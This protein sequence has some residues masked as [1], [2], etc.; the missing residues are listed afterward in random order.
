MDIMPEF[1]G[2]RVLRKDS[3]DARRR[4]VIAR[5]EVQAAIRKV[6]RVEIYPLEAP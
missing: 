2:T 4:A 5:P 6:G 1:P 3:V